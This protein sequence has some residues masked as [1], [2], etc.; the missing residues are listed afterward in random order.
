MK[1][2]ISSM[3]I[4]CLLTSNSFAGSKN[5]WKFIGGVALTA[6]GF[7]CLYEG[8]RKIDNSDPKFKTDTTLSK[9]Q[10]STDNPSTPENEESWQYTSTVKITNTGNVWLKEL[11]INRQYVNILGDTFNHSNQYISSGLRQVNGTNY[12]FKN[13]T[14]TSTDGNYSTQIEPT[15]VKSLVSFGYVKTYADKNLPVAIGGFAVAVLGINYAL[16]NIP[17]DFYTEKT[18]K[19]NSSYDIN[20]YGNKGNAKIVL[21]RAF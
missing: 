16:H 5:V 20:L 14:V 12:L 8:V 2:L 4:V 1:K 17:L 19:K 18:E 10:I 6:V 13:V 9:T 11:R 3:L 21:S 7:Y 15:N